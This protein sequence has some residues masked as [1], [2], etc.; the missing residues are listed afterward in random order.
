[1]KNG[2]LGSLPKGLE[3][4]GQKQKPEAPTK[5][6]E[7]PAT[8]KQAESIE[9]PRPAKQVQSPVEKPQVATPIKHKAPQIKAA[10]SALAGLPEGYTRATFIVKQEHVDRLKALSFVK[11]VPIKNLVDEAMT[12]YL[13]DKDVA[14]IL[15]EAIKI[16]SEPIGE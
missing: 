6:S 9:I 7:Q 16:I 2:G 4:I 14:T 5:E 3:W 13:K 1:M 15:T 10:T 8:A 11:K 12:K